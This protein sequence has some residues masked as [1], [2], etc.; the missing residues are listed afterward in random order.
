[1]QKVILHHRWFEKSDRLVI[2]WS[3]FIQADLCEGLKSKDVEALPRQHTQGQP[4]QAAGSLMCSRKGRGSEHS[5]LG[6]LRW[7]VGWQRPVPLGAY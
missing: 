6:V 2:E 4:C 1:M 5:G 3:V 7:V